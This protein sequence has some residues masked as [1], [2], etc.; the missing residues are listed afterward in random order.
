M[1]RNEACELITR[2]AQNELIDMSLS[3]ELLKARDVV[4]CEHNKILDVLAT[5]EEYEALRE[6][7]IEYVN[8]MSNIEFIDIAIKQKLSLLDV[9]LCTYGGNFN[10]KCENMYL[11]TRCANC[12]NYKVNKNE[13]CCNNS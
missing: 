13:E 11:P 10:D 3:K 1:Y 12:P 6:R 7:L 5:E 2:I 9:E 8:F 4:I